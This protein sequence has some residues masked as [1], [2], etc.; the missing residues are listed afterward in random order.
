MEFVAFH[1]SS[2]H[3]RKTHHGHIPGWQCQDSSDSKLKDRLWGAWRIVFTHKSAPLSPILNSLKVFGMCFYRVL[4]SCILITRS[5][6]KILIDLLKEI[7]VVMLFPSR[8]AQSEPD[9]MNLSF[10]FR[11]EKLHTSSI[12]VRR[13]VP[14]HTTW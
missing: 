10:D 11:N 3:V 1:F 12:R 8:G 13:T 6:P 5:W 14:K 2:N 7:N 4:D 9:V